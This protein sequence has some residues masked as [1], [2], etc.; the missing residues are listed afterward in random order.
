M[1]IGNMVQG[2]TK[3][4][5]YEGRKTESVDKKDWIV[6]ENT[7]DPIV[8]K[9]LFDEVQS[10]VSKK[11]EQYFET[12]KKQSKG[13]KNQNVFK[14]KIVCGECGNRTKRLKN[15]KNYYYPHHLGFPQQCSFTSIHE[16]ILKDIVMKSIKTQLSGL[17]DLE[18]MLE[19]ALRSSKVNEKMMSLTK[20]IGDALANVSYIKN[21]RIRLTTDYAKQ[22]IT[23]DEYV[24]AKKEFDVEL[25]IEVQRLDEL[26]KQR[27]NFNRLMSA[28]KWIAELKKYS[29]AKK[30][31]VDLVDAIISKI[32]LY[33]GKRIEIEWKYTEVCAELLNLRGGLEIAG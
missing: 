33:S 3:S 28:Q 10:I 25:K 29:S 27:E 9:E 12:H 24:M 15:R 8:S 13:S 26:N 1:Y 5:F 6:V 30:V 7:H 17:M 16:S 23:D 11:R 31:T 14:G 20:D 21:G 32:R 18:G 22:M 2:K 4:H 19:K